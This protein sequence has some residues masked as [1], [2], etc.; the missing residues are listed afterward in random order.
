MRYL[1]KN[2]YALSLLVVTGGVAQAQSVSYNNVSPSFHVS[3]GAVTGDFNQDGKADVATAVSDQNGV[4]NTIAIE[5][6]SGNGT[7]SAGPTIALGATI[8][9][10]AAGDLNGDGR[11]DFLVTSA[12]SQ[13]MLIL[14]NTGG[15][16]FAAPVVLALPGLEPG[17]Y[18]NIQVADFNKDGALD[19][20][21]S[22]SLL[23]FGDGK[24]H[25]K[26]PVTILPYNPNGQALVGDFNGD[27]YLDVAVTYPYSPQVSV[28]LNSGLGVFSQFGNAFIIPAN[29][30]PALFAVG[31]FNGDGKADLI[32][33][34]PKTSQIQALLNDGSG[35][36]TAQTPFYASTPG[37]ITGV[38]V[39]DLDGDGHADLILLDNEVSTLFGKGDGTLGPRYDYYE[40]IN[41]SA[42]Q[43]GTVLLADFNNDGKPD[44]LTYSS[45]ESELLLSAPVSP[46]T[47]VS[48]P[49]FA[50]FGALGQTTVAWN[51]PGHDSV[52]VVVGSPSGV[53]LTGVSG[54][55]GSAITLQWVSDGLPFYLIDVSNG[56][57]LGSVVAHVVSG[58]SPIQL[59]ASLSATPI[60]MPPLGQGDVSNGLG[61]TTISWSADPAHYGSVY[62]TVGTPT[63]P[64]L[65]GLSGPN[66]S[67]Q[68]GVWASDGL[69]FFLIDA[70]TGSVIG[71]TTAHVATLGTLPTMVTA[72][73]NPATGNASGLAQVSIS[74]ETSQSSQIVITVGAPGGPV[75]ASGGQQGSAS[76]AF[77]VSNG[78]QFF[79]QDVSGGKPLTAANTLASV[80]VTVKAG[81]AP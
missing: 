55:S 49:V 17:E 29:F 30:Q 20:L 13:E 44:L 77:W 64:A 47:I 62:V 58:L 59:P 32:M 51:A 79:L 1:S 46:I 6:G 22:T 76:T 60:S 24:G 45:G 37:T 63:G 16:K 31:D 52:Q 15:G 23:W 71:S 10:L 78:L 28:F 56:A 66:G 19:V 7:F 69:Q 8:T 72:T 4:L 39:A 41:F 70:A 61:V 54:S 50:G 42:A 74:W 67:A 27:G 11:P 36:L 43:N 48:N 75:F 21:V 5:F 73:P 2:F 9:G 18:G 25:L 40:D 68:T 26:G 14:L 57:V 53:P 65:T 33:V 35:A 12:A 81:A 34:N 3:S 80:T 38:Q